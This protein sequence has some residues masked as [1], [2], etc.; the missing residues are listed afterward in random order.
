MSILFKHPMLP[1]AYHPENASYR[2]CFGG[3]AECFLN[4]RQTDGWLSAWF[5][6][7]P[8]DN[9]PPPH[10]HHREDEIFIVME[11]RFAFYSEGRWIEGGPGTAVYLPRKQP[12]S[13][14][15]VGTTTGKIC[16]LATPAGL[17]SFFPQCEKPFHRPEGP[18][19]EAITEIAAEH[20][21][22]FV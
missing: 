1:A 10:I 19:M 21:I 18:D 4:A 20:G 14:L 6:L 22:E 3:Q 8:P 13:F 11:G 5:M 16:V 12:H 7:I 2:P 15:N 9:G 17:E